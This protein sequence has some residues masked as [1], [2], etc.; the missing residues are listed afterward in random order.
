MMISVQRHPSRFGL[1]TGVILLAAVCAAL[2]LSFAARVLAVGPYRIGYT[3]GVPVSEE[4]RDRLAA[5]YERAGLPAEFVPMPQKRSLLLTEDGTL[6][7]DAGR[8]AGLESRYPSMVRVGVKLMDFY[9]VAYVAEGRHTGSYR[10]E[11][12]DKWK[13]GS[14]SGVV[15]PEKIMKGR[16]LE[17]VQTYDALFGMLLEG[18]IDIALCSRSGA[19]KAMAANPGRYGRVRQLEAL[20]YKTPFYHYLNKK[21]AAIIPQLEKGLRELRAEDYWRDGDGN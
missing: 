8:V 11:L 4:A 1:V 14:L 17:K 12:L 9:G 2:S 10:D 16:S 20:V 21:N 3:P 18:R 7:G 13:V 19:R 15:W 5:V 6:D